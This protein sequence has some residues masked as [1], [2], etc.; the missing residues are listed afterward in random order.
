MCSCRQ[1]SAGST[2]TGSRT[3]SS[4]S[5]R[6]Q[7]PAAVLPAPSRL[8]RALTLFCC[9]ASPFPAPA[10]VLVLSWGGYTVAG[11]AEAVASLRARPRYHSIKA[12]LARCGCNARPP[13]SL[14]QILRPVSRAR[15]ADDLQAHCTIRPRRWEIVCQPSS[16]ATLHH[17]RLT[18]IRLGRDILATIPTPFPKSRTQSRANCNHVP[19]R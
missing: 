4:T 7:Q 6:P 18:I 9:P 12:A 13:S 11:M 8:V 17:A 19:R 16:C 3:S 5:P 2:S 10:L 1:S 15:P 14:A